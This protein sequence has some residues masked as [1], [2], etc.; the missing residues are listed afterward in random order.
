MGITLDRTEIQQFLE[1]GHTGILTTLRRDGFPVSLP[2]WFVAVDD[3][4][5]FSTPSRTKKLARIRHDPRAS[6][7]VETGLAWSE[8][9]AVMFYGRIA[10]VEDDELRTKV[11]SLL[12]QKYRAYRT[13]RKHQPEA[14]R[15]HYSHATMLCF[16]PEGEP[17]SWDNAKLRIRP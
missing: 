2:T 4:I 6:F 11:Q 14:T 8:L 7:L 5:Y 13:Q 3:R 17:I 12:N 1:A 10:E 16:V 9:K 15:K